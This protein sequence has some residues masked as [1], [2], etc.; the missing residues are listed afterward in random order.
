MVSGVLSNSWARD[1]DWRPLLRYSFDYAPCSIPTSSTININSTFFL[2][3]DRFNRR[4]DTLTPSEL[5]PHDFIRDKTTWIQCDYFCR[6]TATTRVWGQT[7][8]IQCVNL[9]LQLKTAPTRVWGQTTWI[10]CVW[11]IIAPKSCPQTSLGTNC[12][13]LP[14]LVVFYQYSTAI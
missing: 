14:Y 10:Q 6:R 12:M 4:A 2:T 7:T 5:H 1:R 8:W 9:L 3:S 13:D 11:F